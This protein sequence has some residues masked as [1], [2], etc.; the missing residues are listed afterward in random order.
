MQL[1]LERTEGRRC[2]SKLI[3]LQLGHPISQPTADFHNTLLSTQSTNALRNVVDQGFSRPDHQKTSNFS[4]PSLCPF[5]TIFVERFYWKFHILLP[6]HI[7]VYQYG[8]Q[9][10]D[11][12]SPELLASYSREG[13]AEGFSL[14]T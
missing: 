2:I 9:I 12:S 14:V 8:I 11:H 5:Y 6:C 4:F 1:N 7:V 13:N 3:M 10:F